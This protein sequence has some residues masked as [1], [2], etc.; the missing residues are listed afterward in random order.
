MP[1]VSYRLRSA[2]FKFNYVYLHVVL[3]SLINLLHVTSKAKKYLLFLINVMM[4]MCAASL[5]AVE[6]NS[7]SNQRHCVHLFDCIF[8]IFRS[9]LGR[10]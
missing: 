10:E 7:F 1:V 5:D 2:S 3:L 9:T 6:L 4:R 8:N